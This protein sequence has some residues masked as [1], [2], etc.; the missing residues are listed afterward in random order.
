MYK[1]SDKFKEGDWVQSRNHE[2]VT[3]KVV[4]VEGVLAY[5]DLYDADLHEEQI[6]VPITA[7]GYEK[8]HKV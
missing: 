2:H 3:G 4:R 1:A 8:I 7:E 5:A 6:N